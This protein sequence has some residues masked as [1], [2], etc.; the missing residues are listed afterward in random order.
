MAR[1]ETTIRAFVAIETPREVQE[2]LARRTSALRQKLPAPLVRWVPAGNIHLTL[3]FLGET[4]LAMLEQ[5]TPL[6]EAE[7]AEHTTFHLSIGGLGL[8]PSRAQPR[9]IW[10]GLTAPP[11]LQTLQRNIESI[12]ARLGYP[13]EDRPFSPHLTIG[14]INQR[15]NAEEKQRIRLVLE[16]V[17][18]GNVGIIPVEAIHIFKSELRPEGAVYT[19]LHTLPLKSAQTR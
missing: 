14:R 19:R 7:A 2:I 17:Q 5:L 11:A 12:C 16:E 4:S 6:L 15:L 3:K 10:I 9:V 1:P 18:I 13:P 8:F